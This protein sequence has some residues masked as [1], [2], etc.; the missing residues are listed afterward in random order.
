MK[1]IVVSG[2]GTDS[3]KTVTAAALAACAMSRGQ[4]VTVIK[5]VQTGVGA[6]DLG[7]AAVVSALTGLSDVHELARFAEPLAP[8]TAARRLGQ[9]GPQI[10][11]LADR[12]LT[13]HDRDLVIV[14]GA[15]GALV[16]LNAQGQTLLDLACELRA[17]I[18][19]ES[20]LELVLAASCS[21]GTLHSTGATSLAV[22]ARGLAVDHLV[23]TDW[24]VGQ[25]ELAQLCNIEDLPSYAKAPVSGVLVQGMGALDLAQF[26]AASRSGLAPALGGVFNTAEFVR[27]ASRP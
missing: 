4:Q 8:G 3:G 5:P 13:F 2:S 7:D 24:P 9:P 1:L 17:R 23:I 11:E 6:V 14:E 12:I 16:H 10:S 18:G 15:G 19:A 22:R 26:E 27:L 25:P 20:S 21:L